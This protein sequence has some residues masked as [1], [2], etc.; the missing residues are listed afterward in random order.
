MARLMER[1]QKVDNDSPTDSATT[2][3]LDQAS[4]TAATLPEKDSKKSEQGSSNEP[5]GLVRKT[6]GSLKLERRPMSNKAKPSLIRHSSLGILP[7]SIP[8][9]F[10]GGFVYDDHYIDAAKRRKEAS[11]KPS[12]QGQ[13]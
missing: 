6:S 2:S 12:R 10:G 11:A 3:Q 7:S 4:L 13:T 5:K 8:I 9:G 1:L